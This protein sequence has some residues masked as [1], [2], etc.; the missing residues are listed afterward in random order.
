M[1]LVELKELK[2]QL[3]D[4]LDK[5]STQPRISPCGSTLLFV[6]RRIGLLG[7]VLIIVK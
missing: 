6:K 5:G 3:N 1:A 7:C 2:G 4:F